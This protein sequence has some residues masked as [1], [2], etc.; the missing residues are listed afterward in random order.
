[1]QLRLF[2]ASL[3]FLLF[4]VV[5][6]YALNQVDLTTARKTTLAEAKNSGPRVVAAARKLL[7]GLS[8]AQAK[9]ASFKYG[10][11]ER[12][13]WHFI[14]K[15]RPGL[16]YKDLNTEQKGLVTGLLKAS[17]SKVGVETVEAVR[18]LEAILAKIEGP[19]RRFSRD[20]EL[21][22]LSFFDKPSDSE[23]WGWRFEG[24]HLSLN[25]TLKG[26]E[27]VAA[28][29]AFFGANPGEVKEGPKKGLRVLAPLE[30]LAR[31]LVKSLNETQ[32][33]KC[34]DTTVAVPDEVPSTEKAAYD[35]PL[36]QGI[37]VAE[38]EKPQRKILRQLLKAYRVY[39]TPDV[40]ERMQKDVKE[41]K[42]RN[43]RFAWSGEL[44]RGKAHSY[45]IH[46]PSFVIN[47][48]NR[49]NGANHVHA[50]LRELKRDFGAGR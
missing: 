16:K 19:S 7:G 28:T 47:Y 8:E 11:E 22:H 32:R 46:G 9:Q 25:F 24:H 17:L 14:P 42:F 34:T 48:S 45:L 4:A 21:Y 36:P 26:E 43:I 44:E 18:D 5:C 35:G 3:S 20:P 39:F 27:I 23:P 30:D 15:D 37:A 41:G 13:K 1:M 33:A 40:A 50:S 10:E 31:D 12:T 6:S 38:L 29:P 49:Q 2:V